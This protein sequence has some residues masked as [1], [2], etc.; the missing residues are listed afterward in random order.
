MPLV[1]LE[2]MASGLPIIA[3]RVQG[4]EDVVEEGVNGHL[5]APADH[6]ALGQCLSG[7]INND[8][9]RLQ[10]GKESVRIARDYDW[11]NIT[12]QYL[13]IYQS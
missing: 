11:S 13:R 10:M 9:P 2:A 12:E 8:A 3:S 4:I 5:F 6:L 7:L 1:V